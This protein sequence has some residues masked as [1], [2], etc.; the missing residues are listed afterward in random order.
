MPWAINGQVS[1]DL[2]VGGVAI[3]EE[4]YQQA[5][6]GI[7]EGKVVVIDGGFSVVEP[8]EVEAPVEEPTLD[9]VKA[10]L[11]FQ[12]DAAAESERSRYITAGS[13]QAM[14]YMQKA[15]EAALYLADPS[16]DASSFPLLSAEVGITADSLGDVA[17]VVNSA[18]LQWQIVGA[19][20]EAT[21]LAGKAAVQAATDV[22]AAN[23]AAG[24]ISW[25]DPGV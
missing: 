12:I 6:A 18:Y 3:T 17:S 4:Q 10:G 9:E 2:I 16:Q 21:R 19:A 25:P 14:T 8:P 7:V 23:A 13:G 1:T 24:A 5:I 11:K 20:I 15:S 22:E